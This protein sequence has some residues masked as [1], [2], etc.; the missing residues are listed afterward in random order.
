MSA[1]SPNFSHYISLHPRSSEVPQA[2]KCMLV[3][4]GFR[5][6]IRYAVRVATE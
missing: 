4:F 5:G 6:G 2:I 1:P 3:P